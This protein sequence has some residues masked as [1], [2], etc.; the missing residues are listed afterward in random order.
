VPMILNPKEIC[1]GFSEPGSGSD[2][3]SLRTRGEI[4]GDEFVVNGQKIWTPGAQCSDWMFLSG[5]HRSAGAQASRNFLDPDRYENPWPSGPRT[6]L[7]ST[8]ERGLGEF[9]AISWQLWPQNEEKRGQPTQSSRP[10]GGR[11]PLMFLAFLC[12]YLPCFG[13]R[14]IVRVRLQVLG[15][16]F[17]V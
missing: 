17:L 10:E 8:L 7:P 5:A 11:K 14:L 16:L 3:A 12:W 2:L 15:I 4:V 9:L 13:R 6:I 1:Q